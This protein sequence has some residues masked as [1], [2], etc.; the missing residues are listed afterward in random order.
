MLVKWADHPDLSA[1]YENSG[2]QSSDLDN[3][4]QAL[5]E[6]DKAERAKRRAAPR[7]RSKGKTNGLSLSENKVLSVFPFKVEEEVLQNISK[8][9]IELSGNRLGVEEVLTD[10]AVRNATEDDN[11]GYDTDE[12]NREINE[13]SA[14]THFLTIRED[15]KERLEPG[16]FLNDTLVDFWMSWL[17]QWP[18]ALFYSILRIL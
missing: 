8:Q 6:D 2:I 4:I 9:F 13:V 10:V 17:V 15:D 18:C 1:F 12:N 7:T 3:Y 11:Q 5:V 16:Q 14:R